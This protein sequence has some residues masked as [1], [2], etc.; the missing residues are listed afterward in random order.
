[1]HQGLCDEQNSD[2]K[3]FQT[4]PLPAPC[5]LHTRQRAVEDCDI[6]QPLWLVLAPRLSPARR[7]PQPAP[8]TKQAAL[9]PAAVSCFLVVLCMQQSAK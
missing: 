1:M 8:A 7:F 6:A 2:T 4:L 9:G 3:A 5:E